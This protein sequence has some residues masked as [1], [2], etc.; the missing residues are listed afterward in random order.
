MKL[1]EYFEEKK[2]VGILAAADTDGNVN[3]AVYGRP[4]FFDEGK[5]AFICAD[6]LPHANLQKNPHAVYLFKETELYEV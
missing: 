6:R 1:S 5:I 2:G 4:H 3:A